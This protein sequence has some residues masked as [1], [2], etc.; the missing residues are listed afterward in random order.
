MKFTRYVEVMLSVPSIE[1]TAAW[2]ERVLDWE[3]AYDTFDEDRS[4]TKHTQR[5]CA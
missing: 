4:I 1:D 5:R 3:G 2:Y